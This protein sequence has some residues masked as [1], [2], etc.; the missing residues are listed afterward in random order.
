MR[1][2]SIGSQKNKNPEQLDIAWKGSYSGQHWKIHVK[3]FSNKKAILTCDGS[4]QGKTKEGI[5]I[6]Q[7]KRRAKRVFARGTVAEVSRRH[8]WGKCVCVSMPEVEGVMMLSWVGGGR[9]VE[10]V[11]GL[12]VVVVV[13]AEAAS[14]ETG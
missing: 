5:K 10:D 8:K 3:S 2:S 1:E 11:G 12:V 13:V 9:W 6:A 14:R 4:G 7:R